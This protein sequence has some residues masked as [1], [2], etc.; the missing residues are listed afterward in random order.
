[1]SSALSVFTV[2]GLGI[3]LVSPQNL[4][5]LYEGHV[6]ARQGNVFAL[7]TKRPTF[8]IWSTYYKPQ[9][10]SRQVEN[11]LKRQSQ[12]SGSRYFETL[13]YLNSQHYIPYWT[14]SSESRF[15]RID[16]LSSDKAACPTRK[17]K[18]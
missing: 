12:F 9:S 6:S 2:I 1:M 4:G 11:P 10:K 17:G 7:H 3:G 16:R 5:G 14:L 13:R 8:H 18:I 15:S